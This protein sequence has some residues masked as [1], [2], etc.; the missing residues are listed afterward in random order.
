MEPMWR[1]WREGSLSI[2][3]KKC[4]HRYISSSMRSRCPL[5][6]ASNP[7]LLAILLAGAQRSTLFS[8]EIAHNVSVIDQGFFHRL[9]KPQL[10]A[11]YLLAYPV[12]YMFPL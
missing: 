12:D 2:L 8:A 11:L 4:T 5:V 7:E 6:R 1:E 9:P 3:W 10:P